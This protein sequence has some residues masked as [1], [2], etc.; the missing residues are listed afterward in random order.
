[1]KRSMSE[2]RTM[3]VP[4]NRVVA[5]AKVVMSRLGDRSRRRGAKVAKRSSEMRRTMAVP[6]Y[7]MVAK[8]VG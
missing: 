4:E 1:V 2:M 3:A 7:W 8:T 6:E 5:L